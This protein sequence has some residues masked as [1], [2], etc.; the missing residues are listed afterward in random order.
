VALVFH[1]CSADFFQ[2]VRPRRTLH[3]AMGY[4]EQF[5]QRTFAE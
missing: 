3:A 1:E 2:A 4:Q 5:A